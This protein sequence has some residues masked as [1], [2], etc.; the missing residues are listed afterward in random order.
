[1]DSSI[2]YK[3]A[4]TKI[5]NVGPVTARLL[6]SYIG[7]P[8]GVFQ[9]TKQELLKIP[10][11]GF[12]TVNAVQKSEALQIAEKELEYISKQRIQV[13]FYLDSTYPARLAHFQEAPVLLYTKG[14]DCLNAKRT[15]GIVGTRNPTKY[16][17]HVT[18]KL[19][20][21]LKAYDVN[22]VSG[23]AHGVD[24]IAHRTCV[25]IKIPTIGIMGGGFEKIYPAAN[26]SLAGAML[27]HGSV[28][29]EFSFKEQ[30]ER[31]H[32]PMRNRVIAML[33]DAVV[34][35][36]SGRKGG[37]MITAEFANRYHKDVFAYP[38]K[39]SDKFSDGCNKLIKQHK[40]ALIESAEDIAY[41]LRWE[42]SPVEQM[43]LPLFDLEPN[44]KAIMD[45]IR[46]KEEV[47]LD[48]MHHLLKMSISDISSTLLQMEFKGLIKSLPGKLYMLNR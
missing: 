2:L 31:E 42:E 16:G 19:V 18:E 29:T 24:A 21:D 3:I 9:A 48:V 12:E 36:E 47:H 11:I 28:V 25:N 10:G 13:I 30:A 26:R 20:E 6:V 46:E 39:I 27:E 15:V 37:S 44:E 8:E 22:V 34:V 1:M 33:S 43:T 45:C 4:L 23:L 35:I 5:E 14:N 32:F 41:I 17:M 7:S 40:A 38:G